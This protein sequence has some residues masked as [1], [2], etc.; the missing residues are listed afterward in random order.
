ML[1]KALPTRFEILTTFRGILRHVNKQNG[2]RTWHDEVISNYKAAKSLS[3]ESIIIR[4]QAE[5]KGLL[6]FL[7]AS[8]EHKRL[9]N[10]YWPVSGLSAEEKLKRTANVV[11]LNLPKPLDLGEPLGDSIEAAAKIVEGAMGS[12]ES[13]AA[14][15]TQ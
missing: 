2:S 8:S 12:P 14:T 15:H 6:D 1:S 4:K 13:A 3:Q 5:A 10:L 7:T 11:G 9:M